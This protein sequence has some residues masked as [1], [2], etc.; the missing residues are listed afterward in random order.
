MRVCVCVC[1]RA[2]VRA[3]GCVSAFLRLRVCERTWVTA[4]SRY[5]FDC[6][7]MCVRGCMW[8]L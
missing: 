7:I 6:V 1:L 3:C 8:A 2:C 5:V 4:S